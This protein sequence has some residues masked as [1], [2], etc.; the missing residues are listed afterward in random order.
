MADFETKRGDYFELLS[1]ISVD[2]QLVD[3]TGW[4]AKAQL[5]SANDA[6]IYEFPVSIPDPSNS[7]VYLTAAS[8]IT[9]GWAIGIMYF[10]IELVDPDG[11]KTSSATYSLEVTKDITRASI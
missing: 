3:L 10:D 2:N 4:T 1:I 9:E 6:L 7:A 8:A 11:R 5:R